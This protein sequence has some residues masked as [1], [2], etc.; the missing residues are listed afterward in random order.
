MELMKQ[1]GSRVGQE[2]ATRRIVQVST[3]QGRDF[4]LVSG[5][6]DWKHSQYCRDFPRVRDCYPRLARRLGTDQ[7][8]W[9]YLNRSEYSYIRGSHRVEWVLSV[10]EADVLAFYDEAAWHRLIDQHPEFPQWRLEALAAQA[11]GA[12]AYDEHIRQRWR[13]YELP[14]DALWNRL[15]VR[16]NSGVV[17]GALLRH[18]V[19]PSWI[20]G[21]VP[22]DRRKFPAC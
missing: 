13:E 12:E 1:G 17:K 22:I 9:C 3:W 20:H 14:A 11:G 19:D 10:P 6:I 7:F 16:A 15:F 8:I 2:K 21:A 4:S 18:P 5:H